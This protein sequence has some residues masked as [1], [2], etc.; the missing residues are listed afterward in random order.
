MGKA[1]GKKGNYEGCSNSIKRRQEKGG[2]DRDDLRLK[3]TRE[4]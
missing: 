4:G 3:N 2:D 1:R